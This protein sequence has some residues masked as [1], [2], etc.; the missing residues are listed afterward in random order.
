MLK[1]SEQILIILI[2]KTAE[3]L[4]QTRRRIVSKNVLKSLLWLFKRF[5]EILK[6][7]KKYRKIAKHIMTR[8]IFSQVIC[9]GDL[10]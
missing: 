8:C 9:D 4:N 6:P 7:P 3:M 2:K 10:C 5:S 1:T